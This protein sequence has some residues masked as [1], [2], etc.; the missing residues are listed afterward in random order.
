M[1]TI[2]HALQLFDTIL[3]L[4]TLCAIFGYKV[5]IKMNYAV[6]LLS[7]SHLFIMRRIS[8]QKLADAIVLL[9]QGHSYSQ[10]A[11]R[12]C[13][14]RSMVAKVKQ[15][16]L[17]E[18]VK[19]Q[20]GRPRRLSGRQVRS[21]VRLITSGRVDTAT[22]ASV[23][24]QKVIKVQASADTVR[25]ALKQAGMKAVVKRKKPLLR[26]RHI[27]E[28][29]AFAQ[30]HK[31]WTVDDWKRVIWSDE[32]KINRF[33]SDGRK[34]CWKKPSEQLQPR[35]VQA[36]V[37][38]GG[39]SLMVWG[40]MTA[41]GPGF[42][43]KIVDRLDSELYCNILEDELQSTVEWYELEWKDVIFQHDNDPKHTAKR[44][45]EWLQD[46]QIQV[47]QWPAQ[48]PDLNPIEHLWDLLKR[49]LAA[50]ERMPSGMLELWERIEAEWN[51]I[52]AQECMKLIESMPR[53]VEA[54]LKAK[55]G[56]TKY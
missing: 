26:P 28:R 49:R 13:L 27:R 1:C 9:K 46:H 10:V 15:K 39:G 6:I 23:Y 48:S 37:K 12:L 3:F 29:L 25:R 52:T 24:L 53:R 14:S 20:A 31:D 34:W 33:G 4:D 22:D 19:R 51:K 16:H 21:V 7:P 47:L 5:T 40:C 18:L 56:F 36:T 8:P 17:P 45:Q 35:H 50:H 55:G 54:V 30:R 11:E 38:H 42:L 44:T 41:Q 32:T 2:L 43:T